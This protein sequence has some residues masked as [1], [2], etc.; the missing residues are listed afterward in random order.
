MSQL[1]ELRKCYFDML[2]IHDFKFFFMNFKQQNQKLIF[3]LDRQSNQ[4]D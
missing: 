3:L 1:V 2:L 4:S